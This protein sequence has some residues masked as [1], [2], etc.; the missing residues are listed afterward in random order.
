MKVRESGMPAEDCWRTFFHPSEVLRQLGLLESDRVVVDLGCGYG[1]FT[2]PA[3]RIV[4]G[5]VHAYDLERE[6][7]AETKRKAETAGLANIQYHLRD[8]VSKG[9][10]LPDASADYVMLFNILHAERPLDLLREAHRI[11]VPAGTLGIMHWNWDPQ[12]PRGPPMEI[13]P[14]PEQCRAWAEEAGFIVAKP[15]ID[16]P[17]YHYG[18]VAVKGEHE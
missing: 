3:A 16:L 11:L 10:G 4:S 6:M 14:K 7:I 1:T 9:T 17:P 15:R 12:T 18:I 2:I 13:R 8:F 5:V